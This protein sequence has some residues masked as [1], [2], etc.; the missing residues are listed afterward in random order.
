MHSLAGRRQPGQRP[1][2]PQRPD[3]DGRL[4]GARRG[5][6]RRPARR[7]GGLV[8][9]LRPRLVAAA[10]GSPRSRCRSWRWAPS[11]WS[12]CSTPTGPSGGI[13]GCPSPSTWAPRSPVTPS[14]TPRVT[15][16]TDSWVWDSWW[17]YD[18][19]ARRHHLFFLH[20]PRRSVTRSCATGTRGSATR[21]RRTW[22]TGS[23]HPAAAADAGRRG[24]TTS[25]A[26]PAARSDGDDGWWLFT[27]GLPDADD[28]RVQRI[29]SARS[30]DLE[31]WERTPLLLAADPRA[32]PA[33]LRR[34]AGGG[35][36]RPVGRARRR[37]HL[38]HVRHRAR[39][40]RASTA[41]AWSATPRRRTW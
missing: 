27:T 30:R 21:A 35:L 16:V 23:P 14:P 39:R 28:G 32:L 31:T 1:G 13:T 11:R 29:G 25:R 19:S 36:A 6:P 12:S 9:R 5:E 26:G 38:A 40:P 2:L 8:R 15:P 24:S 34:L 7:V 20:A 22:S 3:R 33:E 4:P 10:R 41:A 37:R 17:V 18:E